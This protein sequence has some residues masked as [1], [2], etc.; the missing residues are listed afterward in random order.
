MM[1]P[2]IDETLLAFPE[3]EKCRRLIVYYVNTAN[4]IA[5]MDALDIYRIH[6]VKDHGMSEREATTRTGM[7]P[8]PV[9]N[10]L[11]DLLREWLP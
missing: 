8:S 9:R 6:L 11:D 7:A 3:C 1:M 4:P 10:R 2:G 5:E